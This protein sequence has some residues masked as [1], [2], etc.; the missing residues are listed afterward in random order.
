MV[1]LTFKQIFSHP[2]ETNNYKGLM[3]AIPYLEQE[4]IEYIE[5]IF[6][7]S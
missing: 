6:R 5:R 4:K 2:F 1:I 7:N 3:C